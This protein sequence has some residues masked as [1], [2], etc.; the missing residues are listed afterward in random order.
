[1]ADFKIQIAGHAAAIRSLF[2]STRD[3]C[4][5]Y[6]TEESP[7]FSV[8]I[9]RED[10]DF[11]QEMYLREAREEGFRPRNFPDP[12]LDRAAIQ[13]KVAEHLFGC[14]ILMF[15]GSVVAVDG[16]GFLFTAKSGTGK[17]THTRLWRQVFGN[18]AVMVNDDKPF[19]EITEQGVLMHGSP[20]SGKHGLDT[21]ITVPLEGICILERGMEN[22]IQKIEPGEALSMLRKQGYRP[23]DPGKLPKYLELVNALAEKAALWHMECSKDIRAAV[24]SYEAMSGNADQKQSN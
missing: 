2:E 11:E 4:R 1:M 3:Y 23:L 18:R 17:S 16:E 14:G 21:N 8:V 24:V 13:R 22:R 9:S 12:F 5:C 7:E 10:L 20:W 15:H 6:L 19:L